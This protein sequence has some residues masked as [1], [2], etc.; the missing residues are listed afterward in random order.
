[1]IVKINNIPLGNKDQKPIDFQIVNTKR[2]NRT[3]N[4]VYPFVT[5]SIIGALANQTKAFADEITAIPVAGGMAKSEAWAHVFSSVLGISDWLCVGVIIFAGATWMFG[6]RTK[7]IEMLIGGA[8][9]Y[10]IIRHAKDIQ[11]WLSGF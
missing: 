7:A 3:V 5:G 4:I 11:E 10:L 1:V 8:S 9:G 6:N 2:L